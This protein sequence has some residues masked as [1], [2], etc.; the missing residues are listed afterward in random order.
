M[1]WFSGEINPFKNYQICA[2]FIHWGWCW[3]AVFRSKCRKLHR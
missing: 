2:T 3:K 1:L